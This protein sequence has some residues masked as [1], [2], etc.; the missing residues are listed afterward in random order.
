MC[1]ARR[2]I[3][4]G[5]GA[6]R[7]S[8]D[9]NF[10]KPNGQSRNLNI[11]GKYTPQMG[12]KHC[13]TFLLMD[14]AFKWYNCI[15]Y[16]SL[17]VHLHRCY[18]W[19]EMHDELWENWHEVMFNSCEWNWFTEQRK[20]LFYWLSR[21]PWCAKISCTATVLKCVSL[22]GKLTKLTGN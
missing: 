13:V 11:Y 1:Y 12:F 16:K 7:E 18:F 20:P 3:E 4:G 2:K 8:A 6:L 15:Q 19:A 21:E 14:W 10:W 22:W 5:V 17:F 9:T